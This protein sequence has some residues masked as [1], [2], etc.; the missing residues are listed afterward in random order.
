[1]LLGDCDEPVVD[2]NYF[3]ANHQVGVSVA[4]PLTVKKLVKYAT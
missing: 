4:G 1:V 3:C 2:P